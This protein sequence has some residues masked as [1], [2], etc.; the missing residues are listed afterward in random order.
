V[1]SER[2]ADS[3]AAAAFSDLIFG[4]QSTDG[5]CSDEANDR[6]ED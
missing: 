4:A 5:D 3:D 2:R 1:I 6:D